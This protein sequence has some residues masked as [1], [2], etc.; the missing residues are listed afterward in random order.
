MSTAVDMF[1]RQIILTRGIPFEVVIPSA[2]P[3][4]SDFTDEELLKMLKEKVDK[5]PD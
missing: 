5:I 2:I 3:R 4:E 1:Y